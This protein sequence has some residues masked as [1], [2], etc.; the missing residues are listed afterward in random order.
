MEAYGP[1]TILIEKEQKFA[2]C[3]WRNREPYI[4]ES[5]PI[6]TAAEMNTQRLRRFPDGFTAQD[7]F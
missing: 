3:F 7:A 1:F 4:L 5:R 6:I 2:P